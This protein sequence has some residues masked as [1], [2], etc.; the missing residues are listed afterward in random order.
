MFEEAV[1]K[2]SYFKDI[3]SLPGNK[4]NNINLN[5]EM[6]IC[7]PFAKIAVD[8]S[9][10]EYSKYFF[11]GQSIELKNTNINNSLFLK[12]LFDEIVVY[13][14]SNL[15]GI[16]NNEDKYLMISNK[17]KLSLWTVVLNSICETYLNQNIN[18]G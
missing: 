6:E 4:Y 5:L 18:K 11:S 8:G 17:S 10:K 16:L 13:E 1:E 9:E 14:D 15:D 2:S 7:D 3:L 12:K